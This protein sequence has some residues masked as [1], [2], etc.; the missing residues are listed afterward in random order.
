MT[1][2]KIIVAEMKTTDNKI[3]EY[4]LKEFID[5]LTWHQRNG[6]KLCIDEWD[7][8]TIPYDGRVF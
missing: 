4:S 6:T 3:I 2:K 5:V 7:I 1:D 8:K